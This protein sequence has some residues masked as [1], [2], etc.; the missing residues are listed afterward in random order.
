MVCFLILVTFIG[1]LLHQ[2]I[3][4]ATS[5]PLISFTSEALTVLYTVVFSFNLLLP[6]CQRTFC[7]VF[8]PESLVLSPFFMTFDFLLST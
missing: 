3:G 7:Q 8:S 4:L 5:V 2:F 6:I 1:S